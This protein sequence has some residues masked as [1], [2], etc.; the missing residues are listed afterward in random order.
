M[1]G[2]RRPA[3]AALALAGAAGISV[4][5]PPAHAEGGQEPGSAGTAECSIFEIKATSE[6]GGVDPALRPLAKKLKKPP[7][8]SWKSFKLL[9]KHDKT[10]EKMKALNLG[11]VTGSKLALLFRGASGGQASK[12][13]LRLTFTLDDKTGKRWLD[14]TINIDSGDYSLIG[15]DSIEGGGT[16]ILAVTCKVP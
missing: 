1:T 16:Y 9:K 4:A 13:R 2:T 3:L 5:A 6:E 11:L 12:V 7:F 14:G 15:G 8:S 10:V